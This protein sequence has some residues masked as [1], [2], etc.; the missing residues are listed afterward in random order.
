MGIQ[1]DGLTEVRDALGGVADQVVELPVDLADAGVEILRSM[2]PIRTGAL[3]RT[4]DGEIVGGDLVLAAGGPTVHYAGYALA[5]VDAIGRTIAELERRA[6][7]IVE[8]HVEDLIRKAG[9][10]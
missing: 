4:I 3:L 8:D 2:T 1:V 6:P 7:V 5:R 9:L 10:E